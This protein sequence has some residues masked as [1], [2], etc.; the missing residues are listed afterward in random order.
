MHPTLSTASRVVRTDA[1][2]AFFAPI[3]AQTGDP[4][5]CGVR[6]HSRCIV[7]M[8]VCCAGG[9]D[10]S[11]L[12]G[13]PAARPSWLGQP[14]GPIVAGSRPAPPSALLE[15]T[16]SAKRRTSTASSALHQSGPSPV[17]SQRNQ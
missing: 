9:A 5:E 11:W 8:G 17:R 7:R 1:I 15:Y 14:C 10:I 4:A 13:G 12:A 2:A 3:A 16:A 6:D